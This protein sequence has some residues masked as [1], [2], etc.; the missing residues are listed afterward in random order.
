MAWVAWNALSCWFAW[1]ESS[2]PVFSEQVIAQAS[3][4]D[5]VV[6]GLAETAHVRADLSALA[7]PSG[8]RDRIASPQILQENTTGVPVGAATW[9]EVIQYRGEVDASQTHLIFWE[10]TEQHRVTFGELYSAAS[11]VAAELS[12][13]GIVPGDAVALML[14]TCREFF[15]VFAGVLLAGAVPVPI[16]PP[17]RV[18][19]IAEYAERQ[20]A[21]L[22]NAAARL[23]VTFQQAERLAK[24]LSLAF[25]H[26]GAW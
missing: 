9:Q 25:P 1:S 11:R 22:R 4:L 10:D 24:L 14:P 16:Y 20:S 3:T 12:R 8:W 19:H 6:T 21:I 7:A 17:V 18:D 23:L 15:E 5:D 2:D 13:L 26:C